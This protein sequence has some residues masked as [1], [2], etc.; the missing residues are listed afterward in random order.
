MW[1]K[2]IIK[3]ERAEVKY[4]IK[5]YEEPSIYG[6]DKGKISKL[7]LSIHGKCVAN[8]DRGWDVKPTC[9]T[10]IRALEK[11]LSDKN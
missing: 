10:A 1:E 11:I 3:I 8:Y 9:E 4:C 7:S 2:G 5:V 6:I